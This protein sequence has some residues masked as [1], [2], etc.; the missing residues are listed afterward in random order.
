MKT[1]TPAKSSFLRSI[2]LWAY[3]AVLVAL[4]LL[5]SLTPGGSDLKILIIPILGWASTI[6]LF[7]K[8]KAVRMFVYISFAIIAFGIIFILSMADGMQKMTGQ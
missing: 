3:P 4:I 6:W 2:P 7:R 1:S 5:L 8:Y